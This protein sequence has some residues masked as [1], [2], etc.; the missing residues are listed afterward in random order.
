MRNFIFAALVGTL[1]I[2]LSACQKGAGKGIKIGEM[3][4]LVIHTTGKSPK[5]DYYN[6]V[7]L[8]V[9]TRIGDSLVSSTTRDYGG[10]REMFIPEKDTTKGAP[11]LP[12]MMEAILMMSLGD[13]ATF[14]EMLDSAQMKQVETSFGKHDHVTYTIKVEKIVDRAGVEAR[15]KEM[16][17]IPAMVQQTIDDYKA[18]K[19]KDKLQKT[20]TGLEYVIHEKGTG[21][22]IK[23][24]DVIPTNYHGALL[25]DGKVFDS[26]YRRGQP[27]D[28][29]VGGMI[30]GFNE[31][32]ML[33]TKGSKATLFI[34]WKL[35]YGEKG[36]GEGGP[37]GPKQDLVFYL[38]VE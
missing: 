25:A 26:S 6:M 33:L 3:G 21:A 5:V 34:P 7:S 37:I 8:N 4:S 36:T 15:Q 9:D 17:A 23:M 18:G 14:T 1:F 12:S 19:L 10:P 11:P 32:M 35:A 31:G 16:E 28:F 22:Q 27:A 38:H 29:Q 2:A 24:G 20:E 30:P 13:S